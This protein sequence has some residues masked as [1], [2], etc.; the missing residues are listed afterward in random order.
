MIS[1]GKETELVA[2]RSFD[3]NGAL[4]LTMLFL[5]SVAMLQT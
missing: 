1:D 5:S 2:N 3:V 4:F